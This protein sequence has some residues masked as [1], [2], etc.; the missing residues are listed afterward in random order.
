MLWQRVICGIHNLACKPINNLSKRSMPDI[1]CNLV[2]ILD[3]LHELVIDFFSLFSYN[4]G[5]GN[6]TLFWIDNW[7]WDDNLSYRFPNLHVLDKRK[8]CF[9]FDRLSLHGASWAWK[10]K[11]C[12]PVELLEL[13]TL[14]ELFIGFIPSSTRDT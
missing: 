4:I 9:I 8:Y 5:S 2:S 1:W 7:T 11:P 6:R 10:R 12:F 3:S 14:C 13:T